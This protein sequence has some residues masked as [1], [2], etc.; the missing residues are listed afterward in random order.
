MPSKLS[1]R[2]EYKY[3]R[4]L[5][6]N[7][8]PA[9]IEGYNPQQTDQTATDFMPVTNSW[10]KFGDT[11]PLVFV[12]EQNG[13]SIPGG[14][15]T[16]SNGIQGDGSGVNQYA[17]HD[18]TISVQ[19]AEGGAYL[20]GIDYDDLAQ[21]IYSEVHT[22]TQDTTTALNETLWIGTPTPP[23]P[24]RNP[25]EDN[26]DTLDWFQMQGSCPIGVQYTPE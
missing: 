11:Y 25:G 19:V 9:E 26:S 4:F 10:S 15:N 1:D 17:I 22:I 7:I 14:G 18:V 12:G 6:Q 20:G 2:P 23:T 3:K 16:N 13:P 8:R 24:T 21:A 5:D